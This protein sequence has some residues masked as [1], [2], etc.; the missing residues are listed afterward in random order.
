M[1]T[2]SFLAKGMKGWVTFFVILLTCFGVLSA[3]TNPSFDFK[4]LQN[5]DISSATSLQF[6]PDGRLYVTEVDGDVKIFDIVI[7]ANGEYSVADVEEITFIKSIPNHND[8]GSPCD[9]GGVCNQRQVTGIVVGGTAA[10]PVFYVSSSDK[11]VGAG[12]GGGDKNLDTNSG[13]ITRATWNGASWA[14]VDIVRGLPRSEE[15]HATN[16]MELVNINGT[17][18][19]L[20]CSGG[21]TNAGAPSNNFAYITEYALA[22]AVLAVDLDMIESLPILTDNTSGRQYVYDLPT[23]DDPTRPNANGITDPDDPNYDGIDVGDPWGGL[24]GLNMSML[25]PG[26]PVKMFS[27][28]YRNTYDLTVTE[29]GAVYVTDNGANGGWGGYPHDEASPTVDNRYRPGEPGSTQNDVANDEPKVNNS[30]H[31]NLVTTDISQYAFGSA[32]GGHPCPVRANVDAGLYTRGGHTSDPND[33]DGDGFTDGYFRTVKYDPNGVGD[34][35]DPFRALPANWPPVPPELIDVRDADYRQPEFNPKNATGTDGGTPAGNPDGDPDII[36][37]NWFNNTNGIDE[38][39]A[40]NFEGSMQG[41]L[42]A[43]KSGG[44]LHRVIITEENNELIHDVQLNKFTTNGG[45]PL[46]VTCQGDT[47][48]FPGSIWVA[49]FD[50]RIVILQPSDFALCLETDDPDFDPTADYDSDGFTNQDEIDNGTDYCSGGSQ[51]EDT[52]GDKVSNLNDLDDDGDGVNDEADPF[53]LYPTA[54]DFPLVNELFSQQLDDEGNE[55][56]YL[57][58]GLTGLMNNGDPNPNYLDWLD[59]PNASNTDVDDIYGGAIGA[60]TIYHT[61]GDAIMDQND[62]DKAFQLGVNVGIASGPYVVAGRMFPPFHDWSPTESQGL[63]IGTGDQDNYIKAAATTESGNAVVKVFTEYSGVYTA[64]G[65]TF[66]VVPDFTTSQSGTPITILNNVNFIDFFFNVDP[67]AGI[68]QVQYSVDGNPKVNVGSPIIVPN[69]AVKTAIQDESVPLAVGVIG[70]ADVEEGFASNW[71]FLNVTGS[72]P[73]VEDEFSDLVRA[74][75]SADDDFNLNSY[76]G[77]DNGDL[78]LSFEAVSDNAAIGVSIVGTTMTLTYPAT[79]ATATITVTATDTDD[80]SVEQQFMV[81]VV[82]ETETP[83]IRVNAGGVEV[84]ATDGGPSWLPNTGSQLSGSYGS[85]SPSFSVTAS[86]ISTHDLPASGRDASIPDY[87]T[88]AEYEALFA[89]ERWDPPAGA[90]M[91]WTFNVPPGNYEV[92]IYMGNGFAGTSTPGTRQFDIFINGVQVVDNKDLAAEYGQAVGAMEGY[93]TTAP[94]GVIEIQ[95]QRAVENPLVNAIEIVDVLGEFVPPI[96]VQPIPNQINQVGDMPDPSTDV[97]ASGG[98]ANENFTYEATGLPPGID[99]EPTNGDMFGTIEQA[100]EGNVYN[101]VITVSKP[102]STP[103]QITFQW[104]IIGELMP[105]QIAFRVNAG[106]PLTPNSEADWEEDQS[107]TTANGSATEGTPSPY[108]NSDVQDLT[109][110]GGIGNLV[111]NTGYPSSIFGT[112]RYNSNIGTTSNMQWSFPVD[113]GDYIVNLLFA[114][115]FSGADQPGVRVFDVFI[116]DALV[117][118]DFDQTAMYGFLTAGVETFSVTVEDGVL[119]I[120]FVKGAQNPA[121]KG[122]EIIAAGT[123]EPSDAS[124]LIEVMAGNNNINAS[125]F[126]NGAFDITN[127]S[128][129]QQNITKVVYDFSTNLL[130]NIVFDPNGTAGDLTA[131]GFTVNNAGGTGTITHAFSK[132][133]GNGGF[134][135]LEIE[136]TDFNPGE[137]M[138]F[139]VDIDPTSMEGLN[140]PG[141]GDAGSISGLELA[142]ATVTVTFDDGSVAVNQLFSDD[143]QAGAVS[144]VEAPLPAAPSILMTGLSSPSTTNVANQTVEISGPP[145]GTAALLQ[146]EGAFFEGSFNL[147]QEPFEVNNAI[148]VNRIENIQLD[149]SGAATVPVTLTDSDPEGGFNFFI[150]AVEEG[151]VYGMTSNPLV[152]EYDAAATNLP[153]A[154]TPLADQL[155]T[156]G[157]TVTAAIAATDNEDDPLTITFELIDNSDNSVVDPSLYT[158][159]PGNDGTASFSWTTLVGDAGTY[160][161]T[162]TVS[163]AINPAVTEDFTITVNSESVENNPPVV[164]NPGD[165]I[166]PEGA[167]VSLPIQAQDSDPCGDLSYEAVNLPPGLDIDPATGLI[168]GT[169]EEATGGTSGAFLEEEGLVVIEM[170]SGPLPNNGWVEGADGDITFYTST[171][172]SFGSVPLNT[173]INYTIEVSTTGFYRFNWRSI[174]GGTISSEENDSWLK[175]P[176]DDDVVFFGY[177]GGSGTEAQLEARVINEDNIVYPKGSGLEGSGTTPAGGGGNGFFKIYRSGSGGF[178]WQA[179]TSDNDAHNIAVWF[180]QPGTYT[181]QIAS[182]SLGHSI[183]KMALYKIDTYKHNYDAEANLTDA[184]ESPRST[185]GGSPGAAAGSP[186]DVSVTVSDN[187]EPP[188]SSTVDFTWTIGEDQ[189]GDPSAFVKVNSNAG[190]GAST[191]GNN[192]F[193]IENDGEVDIV[194]VSINSSTTYMPDIVFDPVGKAGDNGAKCVT[195]G[196]NAT[197]AQVGLT[198]PG[199]GGADDADCVTPFS[200]P[201]NGVDDEEG[202]DVLTLDFTDFNPGEI[203]SFG[204]DMDPTSIKGDLS[205]GDAGSIS[206][207]ELIGAMVTIEFAN[208]ETVTTSLFDEGSLGGSDAVVKLAAPA[209]PAID[210]IGVSAPATVSDPNQS[211]L[212]TGPPNAVVTMLQVDGRLYIDPGNPS[213]GYDVDPFEANEAMAKV[214]YSTQLDGAGQATIPVTL[215]RTIGD[216]G[217]PEGGLNHFIAVVEGTGGQTSKASNT[218]VLEYDPNVSPTTDLT[219]T[220]ESQGRTD[221]SGDHQV[222]LYDVNDLQTPVFS[223][224]PTATAQGVMELTDLTPGDYVVWVDR[225][226]YLSRTQSTTLAQGA[227]TLTFLSANS[228]EL[229]AGDANDDNQVGALD[230]S[231]LAGSFNKPPGDEAFD[232]RADFNGD[233]FVNALDFSLLASNF[234][235]GGEVPLT[236]GQ[237]IEIRDLP[238]DGRADLYLDWVQPTAAVGTEVTARLLLRSGA[239]QADAVEAHLRFDPALLEVTAIE[240]TDAFDLPLRQEFDNERGAL[241]LAAGTFFNYVAGETAVALVRFRTKAAGRTTPQFDGSKGAGTLVTFGGV[242]IQDRLESAALSINEGAAGEMTINVFPVPARESVTLEVLNAADPDRVE[243][244]LYSAVGQLL[245]REMLTG[246]TLNLNGLPPGMY[247]LEVSSGT[248]TRNRRLIVE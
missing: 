156:E 30:D 238:T 94:N 204:V 165:Q 59:D 38:Y 235:T 128:P 218:I 189:Q 26:S 247:L 113:N 78:N 49:T 106:G 135:Q 215:L 100:A 123:T 64:G 244:R 33:D 231:I 15:N 104:T 124:A 212:V 144:V 224:T 228:Q 109:F 12:G 57:G 174:F 239:Q 36:V 131:K 116:E 150:A 88:D 194:S 24:D 182:R 25:V 9:D 233:G 243:L 120:D 92:R 79:P 83:V 237:G 222:E 31:L 89:N 91:L 172:N 80:F 167:V 84:A 41:N 195:A 145:N 77:D 138:S 164:T 180:K 230:F 170:E 117:L 132:D 107:A 32:Y 17:D 171:V 23:L 16:G 76:F 60:M 205:V 202:Y 226:G 187:C 86:N 221:Y 143:S 39:T 157:E 241:D 112:E 229:R 40:S 81:S 8:D 103:V 201:H 45:N 18:Y 154:I 162:V 34:A 53:Q 152:I 28:G 234:N 98:D 74:V 198:I 51:P 158:F 27:A 149:A 43:G 178:K 2:K 121:I 136:F 110:G 248:E 93:Q 185:G 55:I 125:T 85:G 62:Q 99:L 71:D 87:I 134:Q 208:G 246:Q 96:V 225:V 47:D 66:V 214:L 14:V 159:T 163:D 177:K 90:E 155:V 21:F 122:I 61:T 54:F 37:I 236:S 101:P 192:S 97:V 142:G 58:L 184:P 115:L 20:V 196:S 52:D 206:G 139:S 199:N 22:A 175:F 141:P 186:Y 168:S 4:E 140:G 213:V 48:P 29:S 44:F 95:Y 67:A 5:A 68:I 193:V 203:F 176:N 56:G 148:V 181:F 242:P 153:P 73:F 65:S 160:L 179:S 146:I 13:V 105:G 127:N 63:Y 75:G 1:K 70:T 161:A 211:I 130:P 209:A 190:L 191:F 111:N 227:N 217:T 119:N 173:V 133:F 166:D 3:Q 19:L 200:Q 6:G 210:A 129:S 183:D 245:R 108:V 220:V 46:G 42:I 169:I 11:R 82:E 10:N 114:E 72:A 50:S 223:F 118:D 216:P 188:L 232:E 240:W 147:N 219:L 69:G 35:A 126:S 151:G 137:A 7:D 207:F 197:P 102:G